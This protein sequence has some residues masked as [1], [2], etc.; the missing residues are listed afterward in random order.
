MVMGVALVMTLFF[1]KNVFYLQGMHAGVRATPI[2]VL[3][4]KPK[5]K[6]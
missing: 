4:P 6:Y 3:Q 2:T 5:E 1:I